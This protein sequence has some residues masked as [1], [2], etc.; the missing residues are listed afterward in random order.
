MLGAEWHIVLPDDRRDA[1]LMTSMLRVDPTA[2]DGIGI[3]ALKAPDLVTLDPWGFPVI[4]DDDLTESSRRKQAERA[5]NA[6]PKRALFIAE[7]E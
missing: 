2:C 3:C 4:H 1:C 6:C 5:V 7:R